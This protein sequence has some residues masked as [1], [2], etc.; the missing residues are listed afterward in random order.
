[1]NL[2]PSATS[3]KIFVNKGYKFLSQEQK[4]MAYIS[5]LL[6]PSSMIAAQPRGCRPSQGAALLI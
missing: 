6:G 1:M 2:K 4:K 5:S 3:K